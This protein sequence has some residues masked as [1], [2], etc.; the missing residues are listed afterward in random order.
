M[1]GTNDGPDAGGGEGLT[2]TET[3]REAIRICGLSLNRLGKS[4]GVGADRLSRFVRGD[5][6]LTGKAIDRV[7]R[8]LGLRL[9]MGPPPPPPPPPGPKG[10]G[11][12]PRGG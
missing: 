7:C 8:A 2:V 11:G 3:L 5:R 1:A 9:V 10:K 6:D 4:C 12:K